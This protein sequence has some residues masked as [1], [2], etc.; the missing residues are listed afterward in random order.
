M[1]TCWKHVR[2]PFLK[3]FLFFNVECTKSLYFTE[4]FLF[5][6]KC[7]PKCVYEEGA[8]YLGWQTLTCR[9]AFSGRNLPQIPRKLWWNV[10]TAVLPSG[11]GRQVG[12]SRV[13]LW[14]LAMMR[15]LHSMSLSLWV[16]NIV[17]C[18]KSFSLTEC[19]PLC[20]K[21]VLAS[22]KAGCL[23]FSSSELE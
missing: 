7:R 20:C 15:H 6:Q 14:G 12:C 2:V 18:L 19:S 17:P 21:V 3:F 5:H 8:Y 1:G 9:R 10:L 4:N 13:R 23:Y 22:L 16:C 11:W